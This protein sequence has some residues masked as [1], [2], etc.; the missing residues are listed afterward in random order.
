MFIIVAKRI[1][2]PHKHAD[3]VTGIIS[4]IVVP[5]CRLCCLR[6]IGHRG[7]SAFY[8]K[9]THG[10]RHRR[11][12]SQ[13]CMRVSVYLQTDHAC[14]EWP[15]RCTFSLAWV[16]SWHV[17]RR[18]KGGVHK[19]SSKNVTSSMAKWPLPVRWRSMRSRTRRRGNCKNLA[20]ACRQ[21]PT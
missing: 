16:T 4:C 19:N 14:A 3:S 18:E 5:W 13:D 9:S 8:I 2:R 7:K 21:G 17:V 6:R 12:C 11:C 20:G 15:A 10:Y 1:W